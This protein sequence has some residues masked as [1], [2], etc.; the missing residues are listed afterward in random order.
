MTAYVISEV[1][2]LDEEIAARYREIASKSI[3]AYG[4]KYLARGAEPQVPEGDPP[5][6][7]RIVIAEFPSMQHLNDWYASPEY[8][9]ARTLAAAALRRR[10]LFV[11]G[12]P[13]D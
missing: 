8:A 5:P 9:P 12:V 10:L 11:P 1:E 13:T 4:G 7:A 2:V 6:A 3:V